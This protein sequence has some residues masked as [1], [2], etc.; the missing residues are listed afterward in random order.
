MKGKRKTF[1]IIIT[2]LLSLGFLCACSSSETSSVNNS[3]D[4]NISNDYSSNDSQSADTQIDSIIGYEFYINETKYEHH[5]IYISKI[6]ENT[7]KHIGYL[8]NQCDLEK[9]E[10]YDNNAEYVYGV[11]KHNSLYHHSP[12]DESQ[13]NRF[14]MY[15]LN[16]NTKEIAIDAIGSSYM[17]FEEA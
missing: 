15:Y 1:S 6:N 17:I 16:N 12:E 7:K 3:D 10:E 2:S 5:D 9:W 13:V 14:K 11:N 8:V 4:C